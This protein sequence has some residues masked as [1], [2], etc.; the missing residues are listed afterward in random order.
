MR[1]F[2]IILICLIS[3]ASFAQ[4]GRS[5]FSFTQVPVSPLA[6]GLGGSQI[7]AFRGD[8][9]QRKGDFSA[10]LWRWVAAKLSCGGHDVDPGAAQRETG[11][12]TA[13]AGAD[14]HHIRH[15]LALGGS[16]G[17]HPITWRVLQHFQIMAQPF[18]E[19]GDTNGGANR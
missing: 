18:R 5:A 19:R 1:Y 9:S 10:N 14:D 17:L 11:G 13:H 8:V 15:R 4:P 12:E 6:A 2:P 3:G 7:A 16:P